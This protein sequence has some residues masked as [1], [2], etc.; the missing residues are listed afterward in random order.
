MEN[1]AIS[2][3]Y[4]LRQMEV[5]GNAVDLVFLDACRKNRLTRSFRS[6][7]RGLA[8][9]DGPTGSFIGYSTGPGQ[10]AEDGDGANSTYALALS[11]E[12]SR[13]DQDILSA[14]GAVR[15]AVMQA[16]G[17]KQVPWETSSLSAKVFLTALTPEV[18]AGSPVK[19]SVG[20]DKEALF[21]E[22]TTDSD[23]PALFE[24]YLK[25][26][27]DGTFVDIASSKLARLRGSQQAAVASEPPSGEAVLIEEL[28]ATYVARQ[29]ANVRSQ[30]STEGEILARLKEDDAVSVT[31]KV[32]GKDWFR[33]SVG[34]RTGYVSAKLLAEAD[35]QEIDEWAKLK[36]KP[37]RDGIAAFLK[38]YPASYFKLKVNALL[39]A[40]EQPATNTG[41]TAQSP[42]TQS[43]TQSTPQPT[44]HGPA[45]AHTNL[46]E[47]LDAGD[48]DTQ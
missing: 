35:T 9:L 31:G 37:D 30:P 29:A 38:Q 14:H 18:Q 39:A 26:Y 5:A 20:S 42:T 47:L 46:K 4:V 22:S 10:V 16:A 1:A 40:L 3:D 34:K 12:L 36:K 28:D 44:P 41:S 32:K 17:R 7:E 2:A 27:P 15:A 11:K 6:S 21:W 19:P 13:S 45:L 8:R 48:V 33:V 25:R 23:D 24:S 43:T